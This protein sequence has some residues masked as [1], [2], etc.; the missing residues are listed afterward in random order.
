VQVRPCQPYCP[1][2]EIGRLPR[3]KIWGLHRRVGSSPTLGTICKLCEKLVKV[4]GNTPPRGG[5]EGTK[6]PK[7]T[8]PRI[9]SEDEVGVMRWVTHPLASRG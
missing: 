4:R 1:S 3:L 6:A 8:G 7:S 9:A 5:T 2:D